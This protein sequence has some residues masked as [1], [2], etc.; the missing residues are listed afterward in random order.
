MSLDVKSKIEEIVKKLLS[1]KDLLQS[2]QRDPIKTLEKIAGVDLPDEQLQPLVSGVKAKL[3]ASDIG[4]ALD[5]LKK[6]F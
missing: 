3:A 4:D 6:L 2:F 1:D 5:S